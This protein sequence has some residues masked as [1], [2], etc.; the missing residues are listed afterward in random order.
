MDHFFIFLASI[1]LFIISSHFISLNSIPHTHNS[2]ISST[3]SNLRPQLHHFIAHTPRKSSKQKKTLKTM[4]RLL[5]ANALGPVHLLPTATRL[6]RAVVHD[7]MK[8]HWTGPPLYNPASSSPHEVTMNIL[9]HEADGEPFFTKEALQ[10]LQAQL[11]RPL[12]EGE[13][14]VAIGIDGTPVEFEPATGQVNEHVG[15]RFVK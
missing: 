12:E 11:L 3:I 8:S 5:E 13:K 4:R 15:H 1:K 14:Y 10:E 6:P 7:S 9:R 2:S